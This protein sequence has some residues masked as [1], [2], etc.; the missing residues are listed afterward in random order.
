MGRARRSSRALSR[1]RAFNRRIWGRRIG[2]GGRLSRLRRSSRNARTLERIR[3]RTI[4]EDSME[5]ENGKTERQLEREIYDEIDAPV[6]REDQHDTEI[7]RR[8]GTIEMH[9]VN[10]AEPRDRNEAIYGEAEIDP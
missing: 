6:D 7:E 8:R 9:R 2:G 10:P 5:R 1:H 3:N 4:N